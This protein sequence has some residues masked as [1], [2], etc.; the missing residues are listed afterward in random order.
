[1]KI[2]SAPYIYGILILGS[3]YGLLST[4]IHYFTY[5]G[6]KNANIVANTLAPQNSNTKKVDTNTIL[7][8]NIFNIEGTIPNDGQLI[9][10]QSKCVGVPNQSPLPYQLIGVIYGGNSQSSAAIL[11]NF[12]TQEV[13][14]VK[15][16]SSLPQKG[17]VSDIEVNRIWII[18]SGC[19]EYIDLPKFKLPSS[20]VRRGGASQMASDQSYSEAGFDRIGTNTDVTRQWVDD[21]LNNKLASVLND[22][23]ATP[24]MVDGRIDG[25]T[26]SQIEPMS[27]YDKFGLKNGDT[28][29]AINGIPLNDVGQA[30]QTLNAL[31]N[32]GNIELQV[33]RNGK[34]TTFRVNVQQ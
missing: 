14:V 21:I 18:S 8:R 4:F 22:A 30:I 29:M 19:P 16:G 6:A 13:L 12:N 27:V 32:E 1:M 26:I 5:P 9:G 31:K 25:F 10:T 24:H 15:K 7:S 33:M 20:R 34:L 23:L 2:K 11:E 17:V 3:G 28:V